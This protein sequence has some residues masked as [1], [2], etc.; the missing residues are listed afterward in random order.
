MDSAQSGTNGATNSN[1]P[2]WGSEKGRLGTGR[3]KQKIKK[4]ERQDQ[5][6]ND[7]LHYISPSVGKCDSF[8]M[9][10]QYDSNIMTHIMKVYRTN[11]PVDVGQ[12]L[13][14]GI[15]T[16]YESFKMNHER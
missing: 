5:L 6:V 3:M 11:Q 1:K 7:A 4:I 14:D 9:N 8:Q 15:P 16:W 13:L 10:H 12:W 2:K